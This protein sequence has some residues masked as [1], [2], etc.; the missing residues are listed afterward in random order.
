MLKNLN[1]T[2]LRNPQYTSIINAVENS[3]NKHITPLNSFSGVKELCLLPSAE[4]ESLEGS[5]YSKKYLVKSSQRPKE[6]H[7]SDET[8]NAYCSCFSRGISGPSSIILGWFLLKN[9]HTSSHE[10][11][12]RGK[13]P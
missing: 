13:I 12:I 6:L 3:T 9:E 1:A 8:K 7:Y 2:A 11:G 5:I 10:Q 4:S